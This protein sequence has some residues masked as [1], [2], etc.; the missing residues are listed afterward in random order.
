MKAQACPLKGLVL[1]FRDIEVNLGPISL[2]MKHLSEV[3]FT[4]K[5]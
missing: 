2:L 4:L 5:H 3:R 1:D